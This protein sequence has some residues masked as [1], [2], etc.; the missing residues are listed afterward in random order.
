M[1]S[2][3]LEM[4]PGKKQHDQADYPTGGPATESRCCHDGAAGAQVRQL[5]ET[6]DR[7]VPDTSAH[8]IEE[9]SSRIAQNRRKKT[10]AAEDGAAVCYLFSRKY[11]C[12]QEGPWK[13]PVHGRQAR[14]GGWDPEIP[15]GGFMRRIMVL[16]SKGGCGKST[17]AT[18]LAAYYASRGL[19]TALVDHDPQGSALRWLNRR[20]TEE[21]LPEIQGINGAHPQMGITRS[22]LLHGGN[23]QTQMLVIDTPAGVERG[24]LFELVRQADDFLVPVMPSPIDIH[25]ATRF[26]QDLLLVGKVRTQGKRIAII[27]NRVREHT[28]MYQQLERFLARLDIPEIA[29]LRDTQHYAQAMEQGLGIHELQ[30]RRKEKDLDQWLPLLE[31]LEERDSHLWGMHT[32]DHRDS[33]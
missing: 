6:A 27:A 29:R 33:A 7:E 13:R 1:P 9:N 15:G 32:I 4:Q 16:N 25:A 19:K 10:A 17:I 8:S 30:S 2:A 24:N 11:L 12:L 26:I 18:C 14:A 22:W 23:G 3:V 31:W 20:S 21:L 28:V 5:M